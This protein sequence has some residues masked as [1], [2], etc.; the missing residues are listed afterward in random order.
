MHASSSLYLPSGDSALSL[1]HHIQNAL[2]CLCQRC[3]L[4]S[5]HFILFTFSFT[6]LSLFL[7]SHFVVLLKPTPLPPF[8]SLSSSWSSTLSSSVHMFSAHFVYF[9]LFC[10]LHMQRYF[11]GLPCQ[12]WHSLPHHLAFFHRGSV[13]PLSS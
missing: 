2:L 8:S 10:L 6:S 5:P 13:E 1:F 4:S 7:L 11:L 12:I 9:Y 3:T